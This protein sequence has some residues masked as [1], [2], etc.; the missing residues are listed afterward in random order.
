MMSNIGTVLYESAL[1]LSSGQRFMAILTQLV[2]ERDS[3]NKKTGNQIW[4]HLPVTFFADTA[5]GAVNRA[6]QF[7]K[8][9]TAKEAAK[10]ERGKM[11]G[12]TRRKD[13]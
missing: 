1:P 6:L 5:D 12:Q 11:L 10:I 8:D 9:E 4:I 7:W 2:D 13:A 3:H